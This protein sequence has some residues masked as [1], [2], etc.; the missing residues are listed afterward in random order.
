[1]NDTIR[2]NVWKNR[3]AIIDRMALNTIAL[4]GTPVFS[5]TYERARMTLPP[6]TLSRYCDENAYTTRGA[7]ITKPPR[8]P[9][10][11]IM[12]NVLTA[13]PPASPNVADASRVATVAPSSFMIESG[14]MRKNAWLTMR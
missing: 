3:I 2:S 13:W 7:V 8:A 1:M 4:A 11:E 9:K 14:M 5:G 10:I 6:R 12:M